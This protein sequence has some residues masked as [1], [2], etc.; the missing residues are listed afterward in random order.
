MVCVDIGSE[1]NLANS[2]GWLII[3]GEEYPRGC[4][5]SMGAANVQQGPNGFSGADNE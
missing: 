2:D 1:I 3:S 4:V 5:V